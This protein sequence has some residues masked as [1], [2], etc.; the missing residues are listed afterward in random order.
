M[1][2]KKNGEVIRLT[3]SELKRI[4]K[5]TLSEQRMGDED[6]E[7]PLHRPITLEMIKEE[8]RDS[9]MEKEAI[10]EMISSDKVNMVIDKIARFVIEDFHYQIDYL[11]D[12]LQNLVDHVLKY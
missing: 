6:N 2:I 5:R 10:L 8:V 7:H 3:E 11:S 12:D 4:V 9:L 1:K